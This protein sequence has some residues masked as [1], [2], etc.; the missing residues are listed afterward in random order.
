MGLQV[1][2]LGGWGGTKGLLGRKIKKIG[3]CCLNEWQNGEYKNMEK[4]KIH[5]RI[6]CK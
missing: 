3:K 5:V 6:C 1:F 2:W 4:Q